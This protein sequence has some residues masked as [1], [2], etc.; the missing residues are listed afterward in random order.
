LRK[1][2]T[3]VAADALNRMQRAADQVSRLEPR[4][5]KARRELHDAIVEAHRNGVDNQ[6][7]VKVSGLSR[8]R[9][10]TIVGRGK[11]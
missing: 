8:Q 10:S 9:V 7:I 4:L 3:G 2:H 11:R 5:E 6:L 1:E